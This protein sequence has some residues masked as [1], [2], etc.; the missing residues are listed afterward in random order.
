MTGL[1]PDALEDL[2]EALKV[3]RQQALQS[4]LNSPR[5][6]WGGRAIQ[7][8]NRALAKAETHSS[9]VECGE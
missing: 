2:Y 4:E 7:R 9:S 3:L 1:N 8:A 5:N 6:E